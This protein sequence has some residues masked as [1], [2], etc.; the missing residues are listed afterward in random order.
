MSTVQMTLKQKNE[1]LK[2]HW[3]K[4]VMDASEKQCLTN[5]FT[6][7]LNEI[8]N[9]KIPSEILR[10]WMTLMAESLSS[11]TLA[12]MLRSSILAT[13]L[14]NPHFSQKDSPQ[15]SCLDILANLWKNVIRISRLD[16]SLACQFIFKN[17]LSSETENNLLFEKFKNFEDIGYKI[18][19]QEFATFNQ[20]ENFLD[21][22][23]IFPL[24][25]NLTSLPVDLQY[26]EIKVF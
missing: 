5:E 12:T 20:M 7:I 4:T 23:V 6:L 17:I 3:L 8:T 13:L 24:R 15:S 22:K 1:K 16:L 25:K 19:N 14:K 2:A 21:Q 18:W 9:P 11:P 26:F 10:I